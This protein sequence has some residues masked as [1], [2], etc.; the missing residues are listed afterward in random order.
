MDAYLEWDARG[1]KLV[2]F[3][4][5]TTLGRF[6]W[7]SAAMLAKSTVAMFPLLL[8][9]HRY[10]W[11]SARLQRRSISAPSLPFFTCLPLASAGSP[12]GSNTIA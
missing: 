9:L 12:F 3:R 1:R 4:T 7:F 11:Q 2:S 8:L 5:A 6:L 10:R